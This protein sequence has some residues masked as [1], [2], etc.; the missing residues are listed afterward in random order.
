MTSCFA[1]S[2]QCSLSE[3]A[4]AT[5]STI[6]TGDE[7]PVG[8]LNARVMEHDD[9]DEGARPYKEAEEDAEALL[10]GEG[11]QQLHDPYVANV[12]LVLETSQRPC[13]A[14]A[15]TEATTILKASQMSCRDSYVNDTNL[16]SQTFQQPYC[17]LKT[18]LLEPA[19]KP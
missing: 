2:T 16:V 10:Q 7:T 11:L 18:V 3:E 4:R 12:T 14:L 15:V 19:T 5:V 6:V 1:A 17:D 9:D 13:Y 8:A